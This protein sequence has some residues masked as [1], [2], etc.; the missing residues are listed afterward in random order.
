MNVEQIPL[1]EALDRAMRERGLTGVALARKTG[2]TL[3][4]ICNIRRL[5]VRP[6]RRTIEKISEALD[7][8]AEELGFGVC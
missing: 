7:K 2:L 4:T 1:N 8:T 6:H 5:R 3:Q